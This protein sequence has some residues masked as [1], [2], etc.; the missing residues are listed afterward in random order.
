MK[1]PTTLRRQVADYQSIIKPLVIVGV[2]IAG[3]LLG[4]IPAARSL[5]MVYTQSRSL[6]TEIDALSQKVTVLSSLDVD[7]LE[8]NLR[9]FLAAV[10]TEK[11]VPSLF[12]TLENLASQNGVS[13]LDVTMSTIGGIASDSGKSARTDAS[14]A[15]LVRFSASIEG[16]MDHVRQ[17]FQTLI[18]V[19]R[20]L[21]VRSFDMTINGTGTVTAKLEMETYFAP[22]PKELGSAAGRIEVLNQKEEAVIAKI[23]AFPNLGSVAELPPPSL[24]GPIKIDPFSP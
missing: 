8:Q 6:T 2:V 3:F 21:A 24:G 7:S 17:L 14:G 13:L 22:L 5:S 11:N 9:D 20:L 4:V 18:A 15:Q 12:T 16:T 19:R 1:I 23:S 10:P